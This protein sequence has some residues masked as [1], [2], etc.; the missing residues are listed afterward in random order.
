MLIKCKNCDKEISDQSKKCVHCGFSVEESKD[1]GQN[2]TARMLN[3]SAIVYL[4]LG[5]ILNALFGGN[6]L[7]IT[8]ILI[9]SYFVVKALAEIVQILHDIR[10]KIK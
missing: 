3:I 9:V 6:N 2:K 5:N 4:I 10:K 7:I 1:N 8:F